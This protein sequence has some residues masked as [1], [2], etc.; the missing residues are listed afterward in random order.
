MS[1]VRAHPNPGVT[2]SASNK[3]Q[4]KERLALQL[5]SCAAALVMLI[6]LM[7]Y[8]LTYPY[9]NGKS[10]GIS[11]FLAFW[12]RELLILVPLALLAVLALVAWVAGLVSNVW[13]K[14]KNVL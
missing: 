10:L 9:P 2:K 6:A 3:E 8:T 14:A 13:R 7:W 4:P 11:G 1:N 12:T 5:L